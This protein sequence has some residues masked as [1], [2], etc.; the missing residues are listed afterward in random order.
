MKVGNP[1]PF[2]EDD[3]GG[4]GLPSFPGLGALGI[5]AGPLAACAGCAFSMCSS[6]VQACIA[7]PECVAAATCIAQ[8]CLTGT[9]GGLSC[10]PTCESGQASAEI[11]P[12]LGCLL[13][14]C[15]APCAGGLLGG[16]AGS[17]G[18]RGIGGSAGDTTGTSGS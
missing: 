5:D 10:V 11:T 7:S 17:G 2:Q 9:S 4:V 14:S 3:A 16:G 13:T 8:K 12:A 6:P 18:L 1:K 15:L